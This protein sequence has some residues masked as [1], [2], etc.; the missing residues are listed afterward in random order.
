VEELFAL[1]QRKGVTLEDARRMTRD[2]NV[3]AALML[4]RGEADGLV[5]G[6][7]QHYPETV[8]PMLQILGP[9]PGVKHVVGVFMMTFRNR[10]FFIA[11][12]TINVEPDAPTLAEIA[13]LTSEV[14]RRFGIE[15]RVAML[16]FSNFGSVPHRL[17][18]LVAE[19]TRLARERAPGLII[20]GEMQADTAVAPEFAAEYFPF[21]RIK[22]DANV[23][24]FPDLASS[25]IGVKLLQR[26]GGAE[27]IGPILYGMSKPVHIMH[28]SSEVSDIVNVAAIAVAD[29]QDL[30]PA[31]MATPVPVAVREPVAVGAA[32]AVAQPVG[33][34]GR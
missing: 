31:P 23:L 20:D 10:S 15:P 34:R 33:A 27:V 16:S 2:P 19:A 13:V 5:S 17:P 9:R 1:R 28:Q 32:Q 11:D 12:T 4:R 18:R 8:R 30:A 21:S 22:G 29:A 25:N 24:I 7:T 6:L 14:A 26:L 3:F